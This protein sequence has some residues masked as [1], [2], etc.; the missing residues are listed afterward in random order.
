M[1]IKIKFKDNQIPLMNHYQTCTFIH[2]NINNESFVARFYNNSRID[3]LPIF[4]TITSNHYPIKEYKLQYKSIDFQIEETQLINEIN[5]SFN[6][7][8]YYN[9]QHQLLQLAR[10]VFNITEED[11]HNTEMFKT[12]LRDI[13]LN[14]I[15]NNINDNNHE[16]R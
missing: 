10:E 14:N 1:K 12:K 7:N 9:N 4:E 2:N 6:G 15:L 11:L 13:K 5:D 16:N 8:E 3:G